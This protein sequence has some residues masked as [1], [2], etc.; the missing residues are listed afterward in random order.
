MPFADLHGGISSRLEHLRNR[1]LVRVQAV[2]RTRPRI[3]G[4][5]NPGMVTPRHQLRPG[6]PTKGRGIEAGKADALRRH[7]VDVGRLDVRRSVTTKVAVA[8]VIG[9]DEDDVGAF[10]RQGW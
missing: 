3:E 5:A 4:V 8:L 6:W 2:L 7:L 1:D 10:G 9:E